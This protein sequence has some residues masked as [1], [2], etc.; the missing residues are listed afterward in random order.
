MQKGPQL[1]LRPFSVMA[2]LYRFRLAVRPP[3][4]AIELV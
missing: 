1:V 4:V 2:G 3:S